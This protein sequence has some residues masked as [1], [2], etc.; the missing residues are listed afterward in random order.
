MSVEAAHQFMKHAGETPA[1][2]ER[3]GGLKGKGSMAKLVAMAAEAGFLFTEDEYRTA[4]VESSEGE[5]SKESL[6]ALINELGNPS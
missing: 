5:L 3:I 4:V 2:R 1:L 6:A